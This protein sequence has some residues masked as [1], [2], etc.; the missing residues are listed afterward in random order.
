MKSRQVELQAGD[1]SLNI[2]NGKKVVADFMVS[3]L[4]V[5]D[6]L[7][8]EGWDDGVWLNGSKLAEGVS[9]VLG[10]TKSDWVKTKIPAWVRDVIADIESGGS[11][12][13]SRGLPDVLVWHEEGNRVGL[14]EVKVGNDKLSRDQFFWLEAGDGPE[15][16]FEAGVFWVDIVEA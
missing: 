5:R 15:D 2:W 4:A 13:R 9:V 1:Q 8:R 10:E 6:L 7:I 16:H 11:V 14:F 12:S 3:E